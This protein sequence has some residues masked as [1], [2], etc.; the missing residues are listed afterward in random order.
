MLSMVRLARH[1]ASCLRFFSNMKMMILIL[2]FFLLSLEA[3]AG[4]SLGTGV[5]VLMRD[6]LSS[7]V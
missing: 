5:L 6:L 3:D 4:S 1:M 7:L 2:M